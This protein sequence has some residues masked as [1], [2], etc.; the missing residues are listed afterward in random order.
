MS[1]QVMV[2]LSRNKK[3]Y[4]FKRIDTNHLFGSLSVDLLG[5]ESLPSREASKGAWVR[6]IIQFC[7]ELTAIIVCKHLSS[8]SLS[9]AS[10][11]QCQ[12][13]ERLKEVTDHLCNR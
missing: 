4:W 7:N 12:V 13:I 3:K 1:V 6:L 10:T 2:N 5:A 8:P 9:T 11:R